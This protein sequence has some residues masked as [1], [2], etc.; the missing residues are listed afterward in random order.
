MPHSLLIYL[1]PTRISEIQLTL[2]T[3][4]MSTITLHLIVRVREVEAPAAFMTDDIRVL[5]SLSLGSDF[6]GDDFFGAG[7]VRCLFFSAAFLGL[8]FFGFDFGGLGF[9]GFELLGFEFG[10]LGFFGF[11]F[12]LFGSGLFGVVGGPVVFGHGP[13]DSLFEL[14][15]VVVV[16]CWCGSLVRGWF[17]G[18]VIVIVVVS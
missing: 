6:L 18:D 5:I 9:F 14:H 17:W 3:T 15:G 4:M 2:P 11:V 13:G 7:M 12:F 1:S 16:W 10:R 8:E